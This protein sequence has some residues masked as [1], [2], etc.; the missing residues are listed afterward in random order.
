MRKLDRT[1]IP[2]P[3][4]LS[5]PSAAVTGEATA[6]T[7]YYMARQPW[8][9]NFVSFT[10]KCY[11]DQDVKAALRDLTHG[12]CA[13]CE[14]VIGAVGAREVEHY[15]PKGGI[16]G[17]PTHPGYWW[18]AHQWENLLPTCIDCNRSKRQHV[19]TADM[20]EEQVRSL[21]AQRPRNSLGKKNQFAVLGARAID[22]TCDLNVEEP[23]L[24]DPSVDDP[25]DELEWIFDIEL[26]LVRA[27]DDSPR[28]AYTILTCALNRAELVLAR[29]PPLRPMRALRTQ[30]MEQL[31][32]WSGDPAGLDAILAITDVMLDFAHPDHPYS[33]M[34]AAF[35]QEFDHELER[36]WD[37]HAPTS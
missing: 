4:S 10:F 22:G 36:W 17:V 13:Y 9:A 12:K 30:V 5:G 3:G 23:L 15:R 31:D 28:G 26:P 6:A 7:T 11:K 32:K 2:V 34:A 14:S 33:A 35:I 20:T 8:L 24:L 18:L 37:A 25:T 19:V 29:I 21:L 16:D 27:K 1:P